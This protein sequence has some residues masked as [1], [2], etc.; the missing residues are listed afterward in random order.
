LHELG[1]AKL[2]STA[3]VWNHQGISK[4]M[5]RLIVACLM[6]A[7]SRFAQSNSAGLPCYKCFAAGSSTCVK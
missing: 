1:F 7:S 2:C 4:L 6:T 5:N 3:R